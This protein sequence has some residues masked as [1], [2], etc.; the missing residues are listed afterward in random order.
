MTAPLVHA[1]PRPGGHNNYD[2]EELLSERIKPNLG[3]IAEPLLALTTM[4]L[5]ARH[6]VLTAW[7]EGDPTWHWDNFRRSAIEPH[8]QNDLHGEVDPL[9]DTARECL[10]WLAAN[11]TD[12]ARIWCER[13]AA[14]PGA[15]VASVGGSRA[16]ISNRPVGRR[17]Y[18]LAARALRRERHRRTPRDFPSARPSI[19]GSKLPAKESPHS[20]YLQVP[21]ARHRRRGK[22]GRRPSGCSPPL[23]MVSLA[24]RSRPKLQHRQ[25]NAGDDPHG[26]P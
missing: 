23:H 24:A 11:E 15:P 8:E 25:G 7:E 3:E 4:R 10:E 1:P 6:A 5:R 16:V 2:M 19:P 20:S 13:H 18:R 26:A 21:S 14:S 9:I 17:K 12:I 22:L